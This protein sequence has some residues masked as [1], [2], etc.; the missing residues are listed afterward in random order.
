MMTLV[1]RMLEGWETRR[2]RPTVEALLRGAGWRVQTD[3]AA[4]V[5]GDVRVVV[6]VLCVAPPG[7]RG[8]WG[9]HCDD[10]N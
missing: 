1:T 2:F 3:G 8:G 6:G 5:L 9:A 7:G 10:V 4:Q